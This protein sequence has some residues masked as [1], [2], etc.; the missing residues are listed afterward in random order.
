MQNGKCRLVVIT[1]RGEIWKGP[2]KD[3]IE[4]FDKELEEFLQ[5]HE[6]ISKEEIRKIAIE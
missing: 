2:I 3:Y 5:D 4:D 1:K 6:F